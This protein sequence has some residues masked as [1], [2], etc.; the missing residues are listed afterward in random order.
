MKQ[1]TVLIVNIKRSVAPDKMFRQEIYE[2]I[3][4]KR[5]EKLRSQGWLPE[6]EIKEVRVEKVEDGKGKQT[7]EVVEETT[8]TEATPTTAEGDMLAALGYKYGTTTS[9][10][11]KSD[12]SKM[13]KDE[14]Q[15]ECD[16][17]GIPYHKSSTKAKLTEL[18][19]A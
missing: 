4:L 10:D 1:K 5:E 6:S 17:K 11:Q 19:Q 15:A 9:R 2:S 14:L 3:W 18:L 16:S 8:T 7:V 12:L 13:T